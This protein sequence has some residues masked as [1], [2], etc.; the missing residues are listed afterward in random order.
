MPGRTPLCFDT[1]GPV[2]PNDHYC[3]D[4]LGRLDLEEATTLVQQRRYFVL[5]APRRTGKTSSLLALRDRI[6][7]QGEYGCPYVDVEIGQAAREDVQRGR[8]SRRG[9]R[10]DRGAR[11]LLLRPGGSRRSDQGEDAR[12]ESSAPCRSNSRPFLTPLQTLSVLFYLSTFVGPVS[13]LL[14]SFLASGP[15][16]LI[17]SLNASMAFIISS[18]AFFS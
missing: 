9:R 16:D 11:R 5:H 12:E 7:G 15:N 8:G 18:A 2:D 3:L 13:T 1:T 17:L 10:R 14:S 4:P 6:N